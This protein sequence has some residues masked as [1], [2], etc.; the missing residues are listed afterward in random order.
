M[1]LSI[2]FGPILFVLHTF[3]YEPSSIKLFAK[4]NFTF[5]KPCPAKQVE[6]KEEDAKVDLRQKHPVSDIQFNL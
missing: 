2:L 5:Y 6:V 4:T 1:G 3:C